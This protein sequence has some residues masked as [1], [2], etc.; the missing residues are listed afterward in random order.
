MRFGITMAHSKK[1]QAWQDAYAEHDGFASAGNDGSAAGGTG[2]ADAAGN[3]EYRALSDF[4]AHPSTTALEVQDKLRAMRERGPLS[5][6]NLCWGDE[7]ITTW[8]DG[9]EHDLVTL[10]RPNA[11]PEIANAFTAWADAQEHFYALKRSDD[12]ELS[13]LGTATTTAADTLRAI[14]CTTAGDFIV[15]A[16]VDLIEQ[17][18]ATVAEDGGGA[19]VPDVQHLDKWDRRIWDDIRESDLG[20]CMIALGRADFDARRWTSATKAHGKE[21]NVLLT[22]RGRTLSLG[23]LGPHNLMNDI[24]QRLTANGLRMVSKSRCV[25]IA[26]EIE[27]HYPGLVHDARQEMAA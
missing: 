17:N 11:S 3:A 22:D 27:A 13:K 2:E 18:G 12:D 7:E 24:L 14:P 23:M 20:C 5:L 21:V 8:L 1:H 10:N 25:A 6:H 19:F 15:K 16:F 9:V 26:D 4:L